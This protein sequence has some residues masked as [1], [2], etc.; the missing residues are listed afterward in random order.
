M[1]LIVVASIIISAQ[2]EHSER[3]KQCE[4]AM[5]NEGYKGDALKQAIRDY[6][7]GSACSGRTESAT[8][9]L[10]NKSVL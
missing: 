10:F 7:G 4:A 6:T 3:Y 5:T 8:R 9:P 1:L 2:P